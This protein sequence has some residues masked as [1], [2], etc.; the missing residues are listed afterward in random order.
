MTFPN[1]KQH[2]PL[3]MKVPFNYSQIMSILAVIPSETVFWL[4]QPSL[5]CPGV[6]PA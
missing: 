1:T 4:K 6:D 5:L 3:V 2:I